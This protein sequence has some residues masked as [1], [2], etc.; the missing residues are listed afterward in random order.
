MNAGDEELA[1]E[2]GQKIQELEERANEL[3]KKRTSSIQLISYINDRNRK[4]N[5][6]E[7]EKAI[8][9]EARL[10]K[11]MKMSDPFTRRSTK[12]TM[13]FKKSSNQDEEIIMMPE[14]PKP[15]RKQ[16]K[17]VE[18]HTSGDNLYELHNF[19][20]DLDV[21]PMPSSA[22][23][24]ALPKPVEKTQDKAPKVLRSLNLEDYKK[25]RGLI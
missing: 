8:R 19:D 21:L 25:K 2:I 23:T 13:T 12:P 3:D 4:K 18:E 6:A 9:E 10:S 17:K 7:A 15:N 20:I 5:V 24:P 22:V 11:G 14:P 16:E 1:N